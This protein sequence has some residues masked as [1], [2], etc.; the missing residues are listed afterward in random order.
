MTRN[1]KLNSAVY[2][3]LQ[4]ELHEYEQFLLSLSPKEILDYHAYEY[5]VKS[6]IV[7]SLEYNDLTDNQCSAIL[8]MPNPLQVVFEAFEKRETDHMN[9][10]FETIV[11]CANPTSKEDHNGN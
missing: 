11:C 8:N 7:L 9:D 6:D 5:T 10:I 1:E 3:K 2:D 4:K